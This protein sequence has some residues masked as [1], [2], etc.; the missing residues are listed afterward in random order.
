MGLV[1]HWL[2]KPPIAVAM[3]CYEAICVV[4]PDLPREFYS[5]DAE[6]ALYRFAPEV[7]RSDIHGALARLIRERVL[8]AERVHNARLR[9]I[10]L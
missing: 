8:R 6:K 1:L 3:T 4:L 10:K 2:R 5:G 9:Y 7:P